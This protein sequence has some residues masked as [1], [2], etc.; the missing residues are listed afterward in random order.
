MLKNIC[1]CYNA[2]SFKLK[3][4]V[5]STQTAFKHLRS[6]KRYGCVYVCVLS[7][8]AAGHKRFLSKALYESSVVAIFVCLSFQL[9]ARVCWSIVAFVFCY[10]AVARC[11]VVMLPAESTTHLLSTIH[12]FST[13]NVSIQQRHKKQLLLL[14]LFTSR[15]VRVHDSMAMLIIK[16]HKHSSKE[17]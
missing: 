11:C 1:Y 5:I 4:K 10:A 2:F 15:V 12:Y 7:F 3:W 14:V 9:V 16:M 6:N 8:I 13:W 17:W